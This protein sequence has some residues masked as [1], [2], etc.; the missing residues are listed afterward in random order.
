[1][2]RN[3][4]GVIL[5]LSSTAARVTLPSGGFGGA[6]AAV[7][8]LSRQLAGELGPHGIRVVCLRPDAIPETARLGSHTR[9][10]WSRAAERMGMTLQQVLETS[11]GVPGTLL[12]RP[13]SLEE[14]ANT[15]AWL[16]S[17]RASALTGVIAN[18]SC[19]SVVD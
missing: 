13:P 7:E 5:T 17:D 4:S 11:P 2:V 18:V 6:C 10:V 16:A 8:A 12:E 1:M 14:V 19:G 15:A 3:N 9:K